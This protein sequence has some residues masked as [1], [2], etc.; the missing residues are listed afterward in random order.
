MDRL[1]CEQIS[2]H[3]ARSLMKRQVFSP[4]LGL[5]ILV[6]LTACSTER[7]PKTQTIPSYPGAHEIKNVTTHDGSMRTEQRLEFETSDKPEAVFAYYKDLLVKDGWFRS[8][9]LSSDNEQ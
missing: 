4:I 8:D 6:S 2:Q 7:A 3:R 5:A 1:A 9:D